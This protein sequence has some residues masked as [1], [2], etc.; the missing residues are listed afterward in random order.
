MKYSLNSDLYRTLKKEIP[1]IIGI[2]SVSTKS[3]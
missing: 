3:L 1:F 2:F